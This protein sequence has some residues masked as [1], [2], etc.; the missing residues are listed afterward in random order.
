M[1]LVFSHFTTVAYLMPIIKTTI[2]NKPSAQSTRKHSIWLTTNATQSHKIHNV[3]SLNDNNLLFNS[4]KGRFVT[5]N[6]M[7]SRSANFTARESTD[8]G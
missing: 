6:G 7:F 3:H 5:T 1:I 4:S 2:A 8:P